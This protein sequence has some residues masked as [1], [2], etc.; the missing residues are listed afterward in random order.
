MGQTKNIGMIGLG[1]WGNNILRNL[2]ELGV[3]RVACDRDAGLIET[4]KKE[5]PQVVFTTS[6]D[7]VIQDP[8]ISA[9]VISAPAVAHYE[10]AKQAI[11]AGKD[12]FVEKPL[13]LT[14]AQGEEIVFLA[15]EHKRILMVGHILQYHPAVRKLKDMIK[16]GELGKIQYIYS[17]RLNIGKLRVEEN[18]LW[19]FAPHDI[20]VILSLINEEPVSVSCFGGSYLNA[21]IT[22][23]T[24]THLEFK[25]KV[26]A[27]VFVSWLHPFKEQKLVVVGSGAMA[28]FDDQKE[29]KLVLYP[30][31]I[32][33]KDGKI[34]IA[35]KAEY[36]VVPIEKAEPLKEEL[37]HFC[38]CCETRQAPLTD[39]RE[40]L[41]V[42]KVLEAAEQ[43]M[44]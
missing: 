32:D 27:H 20:S 18:I 13:S 29:E 5:Y 35:R 39:G 34:P 23:V 38:S 16:G 6:P 9:V 25:N 43:S 22:D 10:L 44:L 24:L 11:L 12:V 7:E 40:G 30:H 41:K 2:N 31:K 26:K 17:N 3:L 37:K 15:E 14:I 8:A 33:W 1:Y 19:S 4:R 28:V 21:P 36:Q 42:L